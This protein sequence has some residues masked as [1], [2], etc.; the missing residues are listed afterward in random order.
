MISLFLEVQNCPLTF[1]SKMLCRASSF[2]NLCGTFSIYS[3]SEKNW[4]MKGE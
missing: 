2:D 4:E 1:V 3:I